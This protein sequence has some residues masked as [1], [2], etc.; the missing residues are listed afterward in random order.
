MEMGFFVCVGGY[1]CFFKFQPFSF[2][3]LSSQ[4]AVFLEGITVKGVTQVTTQPKLGEIQ[5][6]CQQMAEWDK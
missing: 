3:I 2:C 5:R 4:G 6:M 1:K